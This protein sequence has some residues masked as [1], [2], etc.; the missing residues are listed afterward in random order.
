LIVKK[1]KPIKWKTTIDLWNGTLGSPT[2]FKYDGITELIWK[3]IFI[4]CPISFL[5]VMSIFIDIRSELLVD[6]DNKLRKF[7]SRK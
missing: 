5:F 4:V 2:Y 3:Y 1:K 7:L 6:L